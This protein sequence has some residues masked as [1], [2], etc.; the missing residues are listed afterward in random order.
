MTFKMGGSAVVRILYSDWSLLA[1]RKQVKLFKLAITYL[2]HL[3][4]LVIFLSFIIFCIL[5]FIIS[6]VVHVRSRMNFYISLLAVNLLH[7]A[8]LLT[9][10]VITFFT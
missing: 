8:L 7:Y 10:L 9:I 4:F 1:D 2:I 3:P 5:S 6:L